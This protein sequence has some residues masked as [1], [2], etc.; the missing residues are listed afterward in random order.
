[1][2]INKYSKM[3]AAQIV[4]FSITTL[5]WPFW[6][7][8]YLTSAHNILVWHNA[9]FLWKKKT[10]PFFVFFIHH[11]WYVAIKIFCANIILFTWH[12]VCLVTKG[13]FSPWFVHAKFIHK[14]CLCGD[15]L[16]ILS[17]NYKLHAV[18]VISPFLLPYAPL[19]KNYPDTNVLCMHVP[20]P[21]LEFDW[22]LSMLQRM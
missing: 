19:G 18:L 3:F 1:M 2:I 11:C 22:K 9:L 12:S 13:F 5:C 8:N 14:V 16:N 7:T 21:I 10:F 15:K 4:N 17:I 20:P 6:E